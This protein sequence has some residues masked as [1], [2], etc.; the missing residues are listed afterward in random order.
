[1]KLDMKGATDQCNATDNDFQNKGD[2]ACSSKTQVAT[3]SAIVNTGLNPPVTRIN[4]TVKGYNGGSK[5][6]LYV[7][8]SG[9]QPIVIRAS[10]TGKPKSGQHIVA[11][12]KPNCIPPGRPTDSPPCGGR[13]A[14]IESFTLT[15]L[16]KSKGKGD[17]RRDLV[18][19]P[20]SCP[21]G[22]WEF[23]VKVSFR[24]VAPQ[25]VRTKVPCRN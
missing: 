2:Q 8:P 10:V 25:D 13:E 1:L 14:P 19:T 4:A 20:S 3:G 17:K 22:G 18:T 21:K 6:V 11:V 12:V 7:V 9:A 23:G 5:L 16:K 24:S 15:T